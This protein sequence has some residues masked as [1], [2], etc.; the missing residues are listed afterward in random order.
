MSIVGMS[1]G[2]ADNTGITITLII[3]DIILPIAATIVVV[4]DIMMTMEILCHR[5]RY[6]PG[7]MPIV[8]R[9]NITIIIPL[10]ALV[11]VPI[12]IPAVPITIPNSAVPIPISIPIPAILMDAIIVMA[13]RTSTNAMNYSRLICASVVIITPF[14][15]ETN[16]PAI[17]WC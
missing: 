7:I 5:H 16:L 10:P 9:P 15:K 14:S 12:L 2:T 3:G 17:H 13:M 4:G 11:P 1:S 6:F 8:L